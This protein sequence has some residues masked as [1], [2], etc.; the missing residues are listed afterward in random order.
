MPQRAPKSSPRNTKHGLYVDHAT[1]R[2]EFLAAV[3]KA[4]HDLEQPGGAI[5]AMRKCIGRVQAIINRAIEARPEIVD[6]PITSKRAEAL[7]RRNGE[8]YAMQATLARLEQD[9]TKPAQSFQ[10]IAQ[11]VGGLQIVQ[12]RNAA[13]ELVDGYQAEDGTVYLRDAAGAL[14][15]TA[16]EKD[17]IGS[18]RYVL[19]KDNNAAQD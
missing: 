3:E 19:L 12:V 18:T 1:I 2:T 7:A 17:D 6:A 5:A 9:A 15:P 13:G 4:E 8:L 16:K 10:F 14:L 11:Q